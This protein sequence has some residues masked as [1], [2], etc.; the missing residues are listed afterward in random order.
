MCGIVGI[1]NNLPVNQGIYDALTMIQ[2]RGQDAACIMTCDNDRFFLRKSNGLVRDAI[3]AHHMLRLKGHMGI[4]HVRY[5][6]AGTDSSAEAQPLYVNSPY[7]LCIA[8]NGNLTN[9]DELKQ[10]LL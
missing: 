9:T 10:H 6:T 2:H 5:P 4:G 7:G 3:R 1:I 8:H